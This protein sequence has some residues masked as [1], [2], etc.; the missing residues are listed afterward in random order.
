MRRIFSPGCSEQNCLERVLFFLN[1]DLN[2][3]VMAG[4]IN[5]VYRV[6]D[7]ESNIKLCQVI[8]ILMAA[9][10]MVMTQQQKRDYAS[11]SQMTSAA[12]A[13]GEKERER[14]RER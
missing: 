3:C 7:V 4:I 10:F 9:H 2:S 14:K 12:A 1:G 13:N 8:S 6:S 5:N 11:P